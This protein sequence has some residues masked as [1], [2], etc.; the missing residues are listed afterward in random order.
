[1]RQPIKTVG[2]HPSMLLAWHIANTEACLSGA[3]F[4]EPVHFLLAAL[5]ILDD[6]YA[7]AAEMLGLPPE[8]LKAVAEVAARARAAL[9][10]SDDEVTAA[11]RRLRHDLSQRGESP[12]LRQLSRSTESS[13]LFQKAARR[14]VRTG[15]DQL[16]LSPLL[17]PPPAALP[18]RAPPFRRA[19]P[20]PSAPALPRHPLRPRRLRASRRGR[21]SRDGAARAKGK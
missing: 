19:R 8:A 21:A 14:M 12:P 7:Q 1:M 2:L 13:Y 3:Q 11:R 20:A 18:P 10:M 5:M 6:S 17:D 16:S 9:E 4:I 15:G